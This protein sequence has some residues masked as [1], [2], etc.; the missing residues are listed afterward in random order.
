MSKQGADA[1]HQQ[2]LRRSGASASAAGWHCARQSRG[3]GG[4]RPPRTSTPASSWRT[5][6]GRSGT[7]SHSPEVN[8]QYRHQQA[9]SPRL[10]RMATSSNR[11]VV[12]GSNTSR[13][14][15]SRLPYGATGAQRDRARIAGGRRVPT[16]STWML[17]SFT[18]RDVQVNLRRRWSSSPSAHQ[19]RSFGPP[20]PCG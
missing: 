20:F 15:L 9:W 3:H 7:R 5:I 14:M 19:W 2:P 8:R 17:L 1:K 18:S 16:A 6:V 13:A 4:I 11:S 12:V 10:S